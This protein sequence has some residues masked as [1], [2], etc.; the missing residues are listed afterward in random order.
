[1]IF[2]RS[3]FREMATTTAGVGF[4]LMA[5]VAAL[6]IARLLSD[7]ETATLA[8]TDIAKLLAFNLAR[9][10]PIT[11]VVV[12]F[13]ATMS[14]LMRSYREHEMPVWLTSGLGLG[15]WYRP[16]L[17]FMIPTSLAILLYT[18]Y[19]LPQV[20]RH[21]QSYEFDLKNRDDLA[22]VRA[23]TFVE[24]EGAARIFF[25]E[26]M[27]TDA[28]TARNVF[29]HS[30][31]HGV[32]TVIQ[33]ASADEITRADGGRALK[34]SHGI[35][36]EHDHGTGLRR[37]M[38]FAT[39]EIGL[40]DKPQGTSDSVRIMTPLQLLASNNKGAKEELAWRLDW[41]L[42]ALMV[43]ILAIPL[44]QHNPRGGRNLGFITALLIFLTYQ[45]CISIME[46]SVGTGN[47]GM[48]KG[49]LLVH[50]PPLLAAG[51]LF[52]WRNGWRP[53]WRNQ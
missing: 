37:M 31:T 6:Q 47:T 48:V 17:T 18:G 52:L 33:A 34:L 53:R 45:N 50:C 13:L 15:A 5:L 32:E 14:V 24:P 7:T 1:M 41:P 20:E 10:F 19:V 28:V 12:V 43:S 23:G 29:I 25:V 40:P 22:L 9:Y 8:I 3:I 2:R 38:R 30:E 51:L 42:A 4:T 21:R 46:H 27:D 49:L 11:A 36:Y 35:R 26:N 16:L 44:A 39:L